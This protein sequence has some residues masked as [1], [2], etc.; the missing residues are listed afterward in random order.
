MAYE[1]PPL[2]PYEPFLLGVGVVFMSIAQKGVR[3]IDP[4]K[5][6]LEMAQMPQKKKPVFAL[7]SCEPMSMNTLFGPFV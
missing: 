5:Q 1:A 3:A 2:M 4:R 6:Q 7:T